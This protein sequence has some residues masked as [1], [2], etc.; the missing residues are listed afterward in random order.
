MKLLL[1]GD[2]EAFARKNDLGD[3]S[4]ENILSLQSAD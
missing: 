2:D 4:L 3:I 1:W